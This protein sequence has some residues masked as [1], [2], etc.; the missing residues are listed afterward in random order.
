MVGVSAPKPS[1]RP[2]VGHSAPRPL[3]HSATRPLVG[4]STFTRPLLAHRPAHPHPQR[5]L[6]RARFASNRLVALRGQGA[7]GS[8]VPLSHHHRQ[9]VGEGMKKRRCGG[10]TFGGPWVFQISDDWDLEVGHHGPAGAPRHPRR[11]PTTF[12]HIPAR[13]TGSN[14]PGGYRFGTGLDCPELGTS[15]LGR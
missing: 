13:D 14:G 1:T 15:V 2:L 9:V 11:H 3:G 5:M 8:V 7:G 10:R 6:V 12:L 4:P